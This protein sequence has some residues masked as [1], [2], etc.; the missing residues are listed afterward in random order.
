MKNSKFHCDICKHP[1]TEDTESEFYNCG[2]TCL[3]CMAIYGEDPDCIETLQN[4][5]MMRMI[6]N[7]D[8]CL[9]KVKK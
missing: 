2:G 8:T 6:S 1:L 5:M 9:D 7:L 3:K 4:I